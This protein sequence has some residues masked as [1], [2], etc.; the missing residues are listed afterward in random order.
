[1]T[2]SE[3]R[4]FHYT[5]AELYNLIQQD[6]LIKPATEHVPPPAHYVYDLASSIWAGTPGSRRISFCTPLNV[7]L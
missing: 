3:P 6:Q 5:I 1:M 2:K 4:I 7:R